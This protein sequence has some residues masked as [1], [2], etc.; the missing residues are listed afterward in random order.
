MNA[1]AVV[2]ALANTGDFSDPNTP[3]RITARAK[4]ALQVVQGFVKTSQLYDNA[5]FVKE[6]GRLPGSESGDDNEYDHLPD[7]LV[8]PTLDNLRKNINKI[9]KREQTPE[10][11][12]LLQKH[13]ANLKKLE[14]R[15]HSLKSLTQ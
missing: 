6:Y 15:W 8:K 2:F 1:R 7:N 4:L 13:E 10:R 11:V 5:A 14:S 3:D 12:A 9:K